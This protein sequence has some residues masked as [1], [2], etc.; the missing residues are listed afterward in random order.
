MH[1]TKRLLQVSVNTT[2]CNLTDYL[3]SLLKN[4]NM[5]CL[6]PDKALSG[7]CGFMAANLYAKVKDYLRIFASSLTLT[8]PFSGW[9]I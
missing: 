6:T 2:L 4:T 1:C 5:K 9:K 8:S 3:A 7:E